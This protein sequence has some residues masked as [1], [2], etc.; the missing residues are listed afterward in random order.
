MSWISMLAP[1]KLLMSESRLRISWL[2][3]LTNSNSKPLLVFIVVPSFIELFVC[4]HNTYYYTHS[5]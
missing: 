4:D 3:V 2:L 1:Y 5:C